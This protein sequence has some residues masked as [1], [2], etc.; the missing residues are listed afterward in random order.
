LISVENICAKT[1][2]MNYCRPTVWWE[3]CFWRNKKNK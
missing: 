3:H 1:Y 2:R